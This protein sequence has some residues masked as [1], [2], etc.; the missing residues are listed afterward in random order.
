MKTSLTVIFLCLFNMVMFSAYAHDGCDFELENGMKIN[1]QTIEF[2]DDNEKTLYK[3]EQDK[4]LIVD[5]KVIK[6]NAQQQALV[7]TY[8]KNIRTLVTDTKALA[9][10]GVELA[11]EGVNVAFTKLLGEGNSLSSDLTAEL[12]TIRQDVNDELSIEKGIY[13]NQQG[14][15]GSEFLSN[16][17]EEKIE[18]IVEKAVSKSLG[19][20]FMA[21]GKQLMDSKGDMSKFEEKMDNFGKEIEAEMDKRTDVI[22]EKSEALCKKVTKIDRLEEELKRSIKELANIDVLSTHTPSKDHSKKRM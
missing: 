16:D 18:T 5:G 22:S 9:L 8:S 19:S 11:I 6:L 13:I 20:L 14:V 10:E 17:F 21:L 1:L 2:V 4:T 12:I 7:T 3:I 15:N